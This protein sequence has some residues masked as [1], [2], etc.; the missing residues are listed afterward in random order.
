MARAVIDA[1]LNGRG[2]RLGSCLCHLARVP[3]V[4]R[5]IEPVRSRTVACPNKCNGRA[6][7]RKYLLVAASFFVRLM[8]EMTST[9]D[10]A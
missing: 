4:D 7:A 2:D 3:N 5:Y 8:T 9:E 1:D 10:W 6:Q